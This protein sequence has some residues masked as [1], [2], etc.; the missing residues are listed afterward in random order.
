[1]LAVLLGGPAALPAS[2]QDVGQA[3]SAVPAGEAGAPAAPAPP[4]A[5]AA[6]APPPAVPAA[7]PAGTSAP[8]EHDLTP[9]GMFLHADPVVQGVMIVLMLASMASWVVLLVKGLGLWLAKGRLAAALAAIRTADSLAAA[10]HRVRKGPA[11]HLLLEAEEELGLSQGLSGEGIKERAAIGLQRI[12][13]AI[14]KRMA[15]GTGI[16]AT[17]GSIGPFVGL[18]GTV[19]GIMH[20]F[21]GI[22]N[23]NTTNL[24]VVAPGIAEALLATGIGL[25][26]AIP[27][28]VIYNV[29]T[30][31]IGSYRIL[32]GDVAALILRHLSRDLDRRGTEASAPAV[33]LRAAA[34]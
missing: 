11:A 12:E 22:A 21:V 24:A 10:S 16:L 33:G 3:A 34:E 27:A 14:A 2:A 28:V 7:P 20:S 4:L 6:E 5:P 25:V 13:A 9:T 18:F 19:W 29:L 32:V 30:R 17:T 15:I 23:S 31:A 1:M 26:A 8:K